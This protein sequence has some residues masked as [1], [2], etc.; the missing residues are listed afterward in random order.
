MGYCTKYKRA[1]CSASSRPPPR[2]PRH[3]LHPIPSV[4]GIT[5]EVSRLSHKFLFSGKI[6]P[7]QNMRSTSHSLETHASSFLSTN[8]NNLNMTQYIA[9]FR[10]S[11]R[12]I[13]S[14]IIIGTPILYLSFIHARLSQRINHTTKKGTLTTTEIS[15]IDS[16][17][18]AV[19]EEK[20]FIIHDIA[21]KSVRK[22]LLPALDT[23][24]LLTTYIRNTM[25][26]FSSFPQAW[27]LRLISDRATF[28]KTYIENLEFKDGDVVCGVY[29]VVL[30][31]EEK[32]EL[33]MKQGNVEGRLVVGLESKG[34]DMVFYSE[35]VMWKG[36]DDKTV[37]P[38]ERAAPKW[39]HELASW[40]LLDLGTN[41][42]VGLR[43]W[44]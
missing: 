43:K 20:C 17:S 13:T 26:R 35:T 37:M 38:L 39:L 5:R 22:E 12:M 11:T 40:W 28:K 31:T 3:V 41:Y 34:E 14:A 7:N 21:S 4:S 15:N 36:K 19:T 9:F 33:L 2:H 24:T 16:I 10:P 1:L 25:T 42:L 23:N 18:P 30:R 27:V 44:S 29:R 8:I 6:P 32:V